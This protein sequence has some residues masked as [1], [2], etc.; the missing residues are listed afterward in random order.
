MRSD[1]AAKDI[2]NTQSQSSRLSQSQ[3]P[4]WDE[5]GLFSQGTRKRN[6]NYGTKTNRSNNIHSSNP[7]PQSQH[8][9]C[10]SRKRKQ[11]DIKGFRHPEDRVIKSP[12]KSQK[13]NNNDKS[14]LDDQ[15]STFRMPALYKDDEKLKEPSSEAKQFKEPRSQPSTS[16]ISSSLP[17]K[18][19]VFD[20]DSPLSSP[21]SEISFSG[22]QEDEMP[23]NEQ[24]VLEDGLP[25][26]PNCN[27]L[28]DADILDEFLIQPNRRLKDERRFC[29]SH[30]AHK[31]EKE[32]SD[33]KYPEINWEKFERRIQTHFTELEKQLVPQSSSFFR[34]RLES[35]MKSGQA[36]NFRLTLEGDNLEYMSCGYYGP[37]GASR[38][39]TAVTAKFS[40]RLRQLATMDNILKTAGPAAYS[41]AVLVPELT[42]LLIKEDMK[43]DS[44]E[45]REILRDSMDVG[46]R[47][48]G[49]END[50]I[51]VDQDETN[52]I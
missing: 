12:I 40:R 50:M 23:L 32:W 29:E 46:N 10:G 42:V 41:Q 34:G 44:Q 6:S 3:I 17:S 52:T 47:L 11:D 45:A 4:S 43:V 39:L 5:V 24:P 20:E 30:K 1:A 49:A 38:M 9:G 15:V 27:A 33:R 36:K 31:A 21:I 51:H 19:I 16:A 22:I 26:C 48:N 18:D 25:R 2:A 13:T 8:N 7:Q 14:S 28:V 37:K 35:A